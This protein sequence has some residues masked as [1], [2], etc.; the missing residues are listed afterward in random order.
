[1]SNNS[2][3]KFVPS[4]A[5]L[6]VVGLKVADVRTDD[7]IIKLI[8]DRDTAIGV[9][10]NQISVAIFV[11][12][13]R[14]WTTAAIGA[15][16]NYAER[17]VTRKGIEGMAILRTG[18]VTRT[19]AAIR[20]GNLSKKVV[21]ECTKGGDS[22][23]LK[24][25]RLER[26]AVGA[27]L[28]SRYINTNSNAAPDAV[29]LDKVMEAV[30]AIVQADEE[31]IN[32]ASFVA[33]I[34]HV[35]ADLDLQAKDTNRSP[36]NQGGDNTPQGVEFHLKAALKDAQA[37]AAAAKADYVPTPQ[38]VH[39]LLQL[40]SYLNIELALEPEVAQAVEALTW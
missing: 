40:C 13:Q 38:D 9:A 39:A 27:E 2:D 20:S 4:A 33:A 36:R 32:A 28:Q 12:M 31:P 16:T 25:A 29:T 24:I 21:N 10:E 26:A 15:K 19:V 18:E 8:H 14:G 3:P 11:L 1:M 6:Q 17:T 30:A 7:G 5:A 34:P 22:S 23:D 35:S 37:I